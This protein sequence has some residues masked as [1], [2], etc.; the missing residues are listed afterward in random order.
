MVVVHQSIL[1]SLTTITTFS[2]F[3]FYLSGGSLAI[4]YVMLP[5]DLR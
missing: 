1:K 2:E 5:R 4:M 3:D